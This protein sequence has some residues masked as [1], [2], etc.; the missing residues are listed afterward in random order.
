MSKIGRLNLEAQE[1]VN[2]LGYS[3]VQEAIADGWDSAEWFAAREQEKAQY[4][5]A[6]EEQ[7]EAHL[8]WLVEKETIINKLEMLINDTEYQVYKDTLQEAIDFIKRG[9]V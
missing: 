9:E 8:A 7:T 3:S 5:I 2:A 6:I 1:E 4:P